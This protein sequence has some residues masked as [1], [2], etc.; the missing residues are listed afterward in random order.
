MKKFF[1]TVVAFAVAGVLSGCNEKKEAPN[2]DQ[3]FNKVKAAGEFV[4][5]L[6]NEFPPMGFTDKDGNTVGFDIDLAKEVCNRLGLKL[7]T[8]H[9]SWAN[10]LVELN[11]GSVDCIW[12][13]MSVD[14]ARA[15]NMDLS[16]PYLTNRMVFT[17]KNKDYLHLDSLKGK[18]IGV[19]HASTAEPLLL[20]SAVAAAA[21]EVLKF[22]D[23]TAAL[24]ALEK[25]SVDAVFLDE[26]FAK[27][28]IASGDKDYAIL[29]EGL[30]N[31][32]YALGFR[33]KDAALRDSINNVLTAMK[34]DGKFHEIASKW[35]GK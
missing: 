20:N 31:E 21:K 24:A 17:V 4:M 7:R 15:A 27:Y 26:V 18:K 10:M 6:G 19:Q 22:E 34:K 30:F 2:P 12:N 32:F 35:F 14:S 29:E 23:M 5:G 33:K 11:S 9:I 8:Q 13:G 3:S 1:A 28:W 16:D 25:D